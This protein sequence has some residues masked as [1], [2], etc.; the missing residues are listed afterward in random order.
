MQTIGQLEAKLKEKVDG[1][2]KD[3]VT[4]SDEHDA[5]G[6]VC[7]IP[8]CRSCRRAN[9][10]QVAAKS[11]ALMVRAL[12]SSCDAS[13]SAMTKIHWNMIEEVGDTSPYVAEVSFTA[14]SVASHFSDV[15]RVQAHDPSHPQ[16]PAAGLQVLYAAV[17]Q[18]RRCASAQVRHEPRTPWS[19][20]LQ[21]HQ[22][23][24]QVPQRGRC[25]RGADAAG[26][27]VGSRLSISCIA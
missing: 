18:I 23:A 24:V 19:Q 12:E 8:A 1:P 16:Q 13:L 17:H 5:F 11:I 10:W 22:L 4:F 2:F 9:Y 15:A 21:D 14:A 25:R 26:H 6:D 7:C 27:A 3:Q 20:C